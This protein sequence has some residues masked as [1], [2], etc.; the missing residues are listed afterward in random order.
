MKPRKLPSGAWNVR[1]M[2]SGK[3]YSFTD[4][5]RREV[6]RMASAFAAETRENAQNPTL[7]DCLARFIEGRADTLSPSTIRAYWSIQ[8]AIKDRT[9]QIANKRIVALTDKDVQNIIKPL[10]SAKTQRNYVN[11]IQ[12][13]T[14][15]SY[16][17][18]YLQRPAARVDV[19]SDQEVRDLVEAF[20]DTEMEVPVMLGAFGGLRRGEICALT[21]DDLSGDYLRI[22]KDM[23][24]SP[25]HAWII[26]DPKTAASNRTVLLPSWVADR[27][28]ERGHV[29]DLKPNEITNRFRRKQK[30]MGIDPPYHF[31]ALR[32]Y[33]ASYLHSQGVPDAY[34]MARG[35]WSSPSVMRSVYRHAMSDKAREIERNAVESFQNPCQNDVSDMSK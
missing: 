9:P 4:P 24:L 29:T 22:S 15:R 6:M 30:S 34:I 8:K 16:S 27:I 7:S 13:A 20:K 5:D 28:R 26:K 3:T 23:V 18:R 33:C 17:V 25:D 31:H 14:G 12:I 10:K 19:P 35:G 21:M 32:H 11:L 1:I 2:V